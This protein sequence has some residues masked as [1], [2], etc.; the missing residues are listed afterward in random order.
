[1]N[2]ETR[3]TYPLSKEQ[4]SRF[5][6]LLWEEAAHLSATKEALQN[7][8]QEIFRLLNQ[9]NSIKDVQERRKLED[10]YWGIPDSLQAVQDKESEIQN[11]L[12]RITEGSISESE[13][14]SF[15]PPEKEEVKLSKRK[16]R[17]LEELQAIKK[18]ASGIIFNNSGFGYTLGYWESAGSFAEPNR[19]TTGRHAKRLKG[20]FSTD[21]AAGEFFDRTADTHGG[22]VNYG[23]E[24]RGQYYTSSSGRRIR[25]R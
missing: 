20:S 3:Q 23:K 8:Q 6:N 5:E 11:S 10:E 21:S 17:M 25:K 24:S 19:L 16:A 2:P 13:L 14:N 1:M 18:G 15:F 9:T 7:R 12:L 22:K 4:Q